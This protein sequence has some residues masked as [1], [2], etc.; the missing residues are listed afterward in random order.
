MLQVQTTL[1]CSS[2]KEEEVEE[3]KSVDSQT[4]ETLLAKQE[5]EDDLPEQ[6]EIV[7]SD[8]NQDKND[9]TNFALD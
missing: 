6:G 7:E 2:D 9:G 1:V 5:G 8:E 4:E 3:T